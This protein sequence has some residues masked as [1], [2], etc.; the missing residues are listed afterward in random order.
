MSMYVGNG[1]IRI[2][3]KYILKDEIALD[4]LNAYDYIFLLE[5]QKKL[6]SYSL[7]FDNQFNIGDEFFHFHLHSHYIIR[8][9]FL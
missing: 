4:N 7:A 2:E 9:E 5:V 8:V 3:N 1:E 6:G